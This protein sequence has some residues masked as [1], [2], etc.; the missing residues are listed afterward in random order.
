MQQKYNTDSVRYGTEFETKFSVCSRPLSG[1][2]GV[3]RSKARQPAIGRPALQKRVRVH[4]ITLHD[5]ADTT[6]SPHQFDKAH[7]VCGH[8]VKN[9]QERTCTS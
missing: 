8:G 1:G 5:Y 4:C 3:P 2:P 7:I 9:I 6:H